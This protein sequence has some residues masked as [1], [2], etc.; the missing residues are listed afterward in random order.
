MN[1]GFIGAGK[2]GFS[3]G[4]YLS[5]KGV[6]IAGY[7]SRRESSAL[8]AA[9]FTGSK[10]FS[11]PEELIRQCDCVLL[12]VPDD[13]IAKVWNDLRQADIAGKI[14]CHC[15][16]SLSSDIFHGAEE[17]GAGGCSLHPLAAVPD[18]YHSHTLLADAVFTLEGAPEA[19]D[20]LYR[21]VSG[22]GNPVYVLDKAMKTRYHC[23]AVFVSNFSTALASVGAELFRSCGLE[24][25]DGPLFQLMLNNVRSVCEYGVVHALTGPVERGDAQTVGR[26]LACLSAEDRQ[27]YALL[28]RKLVRI[29]AAKH[30]DRDFGPVLETLGET[31]SCFNPQSPHPSTD[32][33]ADRQ[34][35]CGL[36]L[37]EGRG[38]RKGFH[39]LR[40]FV[41]TMFPP[42]G[43]GFKP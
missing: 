39:R 2:V 42:E 16:G 22:L 4:R 35:S 38:Y 7:A 27:L 43:G 37:H 20:A 34:V 33:A 25:A 5:G 19:R 14:F 26:H 12:T 18:L 28:A 24:Q 29:A 40:R 6:R 15:S 17:R 32:S 1:I 21:L 30:A 8:R 41:N 13:A 36:P 11:R 9:A 31:A 10:A 3:L 23:A